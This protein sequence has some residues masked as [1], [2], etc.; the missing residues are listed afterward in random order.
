M[1]VLQN[2]NDSIYETSLEF[3][4]ND[5]LQQLVGARNMH[6]KRLEKQLGVRIALRGNILSL[7]GETINTQNAEQVLKNLYENLE[8]GKSMDV[9][10]IDHQIAKS[11]SKDM[12][13]EIRIKLKTDART[14]VP[15]S[16]NQEELIKLLEKDELVFALGPAGTGKTYIA[17]A[18]GV[19]MLMSGRIDKLIISRPAI[20][21]GEKLGFLPGDLKEKVDPYLRP[22]YDALHDMFHESHIE[23]LVNSG[24]I[25]IAPLAFMRGRTLSNAF[26]ILDEAQNTT[27]LQMKMFLTRLGEGSRMVVTGDVTQI[28][29]PMENQSG[30]V[31]AMKRFHDIESISFMEFGAE[32]VVRHPL[33]GRIVKAYAKR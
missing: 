16:K 21:A 7:Q 31:D 33:V 14:I 1:S 28:D 26:I 13:A 12:A 11:K 22:I 19:S 6:L 24:S 15:R 20:E 5:I 9:A 4:K 3:Q 8:R 30:L 18:M 27:I 25:E 17:V 29:L 32:D 2:S 23:K 10:Q